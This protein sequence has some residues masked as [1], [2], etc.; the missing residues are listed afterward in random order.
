MGG[1]RLPVLVPCGCHAD[2][3]AVFA[4]VVFDFTRLELQLRHFTAQGCHDSRPHVSLGGSHLGGGGGARWHPHQ[5]STQKPLKW[6]GQECGFGKHLRNQLTSIF[7]DGKTKVWVVS[8]HLLMPPAST[9]PHTPHSFRWSLCT[10]GCSWAESLTAGTQQPAWPSALT[11]LPGA[12]KPLVNATFIERCT[13]GQVRGGTVTK[14]THFGVKPG[15]KCW[16]PTNQV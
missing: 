1:E 15:F 3:Q 13:H 10:P 5:T 9:F 2:P 16:L 14:N 6:G 4:D 12:S 11:Q 7:H 8:I